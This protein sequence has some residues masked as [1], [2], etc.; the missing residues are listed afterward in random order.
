MGN[1]N[2]FEF[3]PLGP[4]MY[5]SLPQEMR[6][7]MSSC[8]IM[9]TMPRIEF[10]N[11]GCG[12][13]GQ[14]IDLKKIN[15]NMEV[16]EVNLKEEENTIDYIRFR[17]VELKYDSSEDDEKVDRVLKDIESNNEGVLKFLQVNGMPYDKAKKFIK[18]IIRLS[19]RYGD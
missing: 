19:L 11:L 18:R 17:D 4:I 6:G 12:I 16:S 14:I 15:E 3:V 1:E 7:F 10:Q 9:G 2:E 5:N 8:G 13:E